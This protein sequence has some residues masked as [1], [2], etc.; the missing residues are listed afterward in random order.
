MQKMSRNQGEFGN[1][2]QKMSRA[3]SA[4]WSGFPLFF[5]PFSRAFE[6]EMKEKPGSDVADAPDLEAA[7]GASFSAFYSQI[8]LDLCSFSAFYSQIPLIYV[9]KWGVYAMK[10]IKF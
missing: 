8:P 4:T 10:C 2:M 7:R 5:L 6:S 1:K 9:L 3:A